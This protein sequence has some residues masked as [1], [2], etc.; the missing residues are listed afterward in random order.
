MYILK[1]ADGTHTELGSSTGNRADELDGTFWITG[2]SAGTRAAVVEG[3]FYTLV[4]AD[5][6]SNSVEVMEVGG[7]GMGGLRFELTG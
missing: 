3:G 6:H 5:G 1:E 7:A 2:W 4:F